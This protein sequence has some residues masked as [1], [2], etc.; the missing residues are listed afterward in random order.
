MRYT[1]QA[2]AVENVVYTVLSGNVGNLPQVENFLINYG[3]SVI[4]TPSDFPFPTDAVAATA[5]FNSE[6]V[7]VSDLDLVVLE[8]TRELDSVRPLRDRRSD[9]YEVVPRDAVEVVTVK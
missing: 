4:C 6:T 9:L 1:S 3:H 5:D 7:V 2:R 8:E